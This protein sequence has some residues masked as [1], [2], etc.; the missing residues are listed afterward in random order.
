MQAMYFR[1]FIWGPI[2]PFVTGF[3]GPTGPPCKTQHWKIT[4]LETENPS[5]ETTGIL[6]SCGGGRM[7]LSY[8]S[9]QSP[10]ILKNVL[11]KYMILKFWIMCFPLLR[12]EHAKTK[13]TPP[14]FL[15]YPPNNSPRHLLT[16]PIFYHISNPLLFKW[17]LDINGIYCFP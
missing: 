8:E 12:V 16:T 15:P 10:S 17:Q 14:L 6:T 3:V 2:S 13:N 4:I 5:L 7:L 1:P 9:G 11:S